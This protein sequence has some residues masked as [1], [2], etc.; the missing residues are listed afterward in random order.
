MLPVLLSP[1]LAL[2]LGAAPA[3]D[4]PHF[5]I[6]RPAALGGR[7]VGGQL[8]IVRVTVAGREGLFLFDTGASDTVLGRH[9]AEALGLAGGSAGA[10]SDSGG[11][12]V[13]ARSIENVDIA[14]GTVRRHFPRL[15]VASIGPL[16]A[17]G[18]DGVISP[19][20]LVGP[21]CLRIGFDTGIAMLAPA[22]SPA[23]TL[24]GA[25]VSIGADRRPHIDAGDMTGASADFLLDSGAWRT[26]LPA[27]FASDTPALGNEAHG[28]VAG[29]TTRSDLIGPVSL[30]L[31]GKP[32]RLESVRRAAPGKGG[33]IGFDLLARA[34]L[35]LRPDKEARL[36]FP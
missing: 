21:A 4:L 15:V 28:G 23:C 35:L 11:N 16:E 30:Q 29:P 22:S 25:T 7:A 8:P 31:G 9:F 2:L 3:P 6:E 10:G 14:I 1:V 36:L 20:S 12:A 17:L 32:V 27:G 24:E 26:A 34:V 19:Q 33:V 5:T 13:A 18:I